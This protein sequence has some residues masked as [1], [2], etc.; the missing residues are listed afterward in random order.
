MKAV[1]PV[2]RQPVLWTASFF[3]IFLIVLVVTALS[4]LFWL[5]ALRGT[6]WRVQAEGNRRQRVTI[7]AP[8]GVLTDRNGVVIA[9]NN[10]VFLQPYVD[11]DRRSQ[12]RPLTAEEAVQLQ[13]T[14]PAMLKKIYVR[15]YPYGPTLSHILGYVSRVRSSVDRG[16]G[17][18][19]IE[20]YL[21]K[22]LTGIDGEVWYER[23]ARGVAQRVLA[24]REP[25]AGKS[26]QL[27]LD[28]ELSQIAFDAL[29]GQRGS[30]VVTTPRG[31]VLV[32]VSK[33]SFQPIFPDQIQAGQAMTHP[34]VSASPSAQEINRALV[35]P[36]LPT[37]LKD[38]KSPLLFRAFSGTYPPGSVF[39]VVTALAG[40]ER[41]A[42]TSTTTVTDEGVLRVGEFTFQNWYWRQYGGVDGTINV[43]RALGRSNDIFFY[44]LAEWVGPESLAEFAQWLGYGNPTGIEGQREQIGLVPTPGWKQRTFGERW[45]LGNTFHMGI[46]QGDV[47]VTPAQVSVMMNTVASRG[48]QCQLHLIPDSV[49]ACQEISLQPETWDTVVRG[50]REACAPG[51]TAYPFFDSPYD[52][53]CKTGT[54]EFG[55]ADERGYRP[56]HGWFVVA[57][58]SEERQDVGTAEFDPEIVVTVMVESDETQLYK[59]GSRDAAPIARTIIDAWLARQS[60]PESSVDTSA[61]APVE[62]EAESPT[63]E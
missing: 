20:Q 29:G 51:G 2:I 22:E 16:L 36:D 45:F 5:Q 32:A 33:P 55:A 21:N 39:K 35:S 7:P 27:T 14:A 26:V 31:E 25:Q 23:S 50:L 61:E 38:E 42:I 54:A 8:R 13:A 17:E 28:A 34:Q 52:A 11:E 56:T 1:L 48:R 12:E 15:N 10:V 44:R 6:I 59:E 62:S 49:T 40:L 46:G 63:E 4:R 47:L 57:A 58:S 9:R 41:G 19:G 24:E 60:P 3:R 37:A 30:V 18:A 43:V 53:M